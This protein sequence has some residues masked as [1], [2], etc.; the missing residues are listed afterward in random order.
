VTIRSEHDTELIDTNVRVVG[1]HK[2]D[3]VLVTG[4]RVLI[5]RSDAQILTPDVT[6][7]RMA[8]PM[9][10]T[11]AARQA[12][13]DWGRTADDAAF[14]RL[15]SALAAWPL[16]RGLARSQGWPLDRRP[17]PSE[18]VLRLLDQFDGATG[19]AD[20]DR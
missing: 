14:D 15:K 2:E 9:S 13:A 10:E 18:V 5:D 19:G 3:G 16:G 1:T 20:Q 17:W 11:E 8:P 7:G 6:R 12:L 4:F